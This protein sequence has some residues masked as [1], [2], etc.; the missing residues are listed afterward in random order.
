MSRPFQR[1]SAPP[2]R[3]GHQLPRCATWSRGEPR[4]KV[5]EFPPG[6]KSRARRVLPPVASRP[7]KN[8]L[9]RLGPRNRDRATPSGSGTATA[10]GPALSPLDSTGPRRITAGSRPRCREHAPDHLGDPLDQLPHLRTGPRFRRHPLPSPGCGF[11]CE[12][13]RSSLRSRM[14]G[15]PAPF[16]LF[17]VI[18][19]LP[20]AGSGR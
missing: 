19:E 4:R 3:G 16:H 17:K 13:C 5:G 10:G 18:P 8:R 6:G 7:A 1:S 9:K 11:G 12:L 2:S 14:T 15:L 20:F